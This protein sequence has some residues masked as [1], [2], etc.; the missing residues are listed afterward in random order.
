MVDI[1]GG[2]PESKTIEIMDMHGRVMN[3]RRLPPGYGSL[4]EFDLSDASPGLYL[5]RVQEGQE[6]LTSKILIKR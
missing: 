1:G 3:S 2:N 5:I 4:E 6:C